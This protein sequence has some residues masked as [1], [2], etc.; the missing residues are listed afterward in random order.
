MGLYIAKSLMQKMSGDL[1]AESDGDG[2]LIKLIIKYQ[3]VVFL[4]IRRQPVIHQFFI[5]KIKRIIDL[6]N[7]QFISFTSIAKKKLHKIFI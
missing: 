7:W 5:F 4:L 1:I 3:V 2:L 6:I